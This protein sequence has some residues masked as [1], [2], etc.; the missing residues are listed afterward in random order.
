MSITGQTKSSGVSLDPSSRTATTMYGMTKA[1]QGWK[2]NDPYLTYDG[3][4]DADGRKVL[5]NSIGSAIT[6]T[7]LTKNAI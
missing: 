5:Y 2:Y 7:P 3:E 6:L 1:G 4:T